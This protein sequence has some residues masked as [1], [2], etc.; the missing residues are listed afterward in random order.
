MRLPAID[1]DLLQVLK[2]WEFHSAQ[3]K[4]LYGE[5]ERT[6]FEWTFLTQKHAKGSFAYRAPDQG[7]FRMSGLDVQIGGK[8]DVRTNPINRKKQQLTL[9]EDK[10]EHWICTGKELISIDHQAKTLERMVIPPQNRGQGIMETPL[11]FLFGMK[12]QQARAR[13]EMKFLP[14]KKD[15]PNEVWLSAKPLWPADAANYKEAKVIL[16][17]KTFLPRAVLLTNP[18]GTAETI[19]QFSNFRTKLNF[20]EPKPFEQPL[21]KYK[22]VQTARGGD[23][24][25]GPA[26][27][28]T[29]DAK[30]R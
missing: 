25:S 9:A 7:I 1:G 23:A 5:V 3:V 13:Y 6:T 24:N 18:A 27:T 4:I 2:D 19:Y 22:Q 14:D 16:S 10:E 21:P 17:R 29:P 28:R 15:D 8:G 11:P 12:V 30:R 20:L 26:A